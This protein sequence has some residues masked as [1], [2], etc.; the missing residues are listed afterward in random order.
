LKDGEDI[1]E[2]C[3]RLKCLVSQVLEVLG[4]VAYPHDNLRVSMKKYNL[5]WDE[6]L[7]DQVRWDA[8]HAA[9]VVMREALAWSDDEG[10]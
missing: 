8:Q 1:I 6:R 10:R 3:H 2:C 9:A 7:I 4:T 5:P